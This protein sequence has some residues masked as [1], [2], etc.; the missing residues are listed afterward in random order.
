MSGDSGL[1]AF[2]FGGAAG[3]VVL[4]A[5]RLHMEDGAFI[6]N[7][8]TREAR[9]G[10]I[11]VN[12]GTLT[13]RDDAAISGSTSGSQVAGTVIITA[14]K[15]IDIAGTERSA[16]RSNAS[17]GTSPPLGDAGQITL[18]APDIT[19]GGKSQIAT[20]T[21]GKG[22]GGDITIKA[23]RHLRVQESAVI[24]SSTTATGDAGGIVL[25]APRVTLEDQGRIQAT[26]EDTGRGGRIVV[27][28]GRV[29]LSGGAQIDSSSAGN[30]RGGRT[31]IT[32][33]D[34]VMLSGAKSGIFTTSVGRKRGGD[35]ALQARIVQ[36]T[37]GAVVAAESTGAGNAGSVTIT[38]TDS[39]LS[40]HSTVTTD[41]DRADG[42]NIH[43]T[44]TDAGAA[45]R[46]PGDRHRRRGTRH[47]RWQY[48]HRP[49]VRHPGEQPDRGQCLRRAGRR[50]PNHGTRGISGRSG[51]SGGCL[52]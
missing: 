2:S 39:F 27:K 47:H 23:D 20:I 16:I 11:K 18:S 9:G 48:H 41:A 3:N 28:A 7:L 1:L 6:T 35:I 22:R 40:E 21:Q 37:A 17:P 13:M 32:A 29:T 8:T 10:V 25:A 45:A 52:V 30:G 26:T 34:M 51:Q 42:G 38:A 5:N 12:V 15:A 50:H 19:I 4:S 31:H 49:R 43:G 14:T 36:L 24:T 46:Q 33:T 44:G